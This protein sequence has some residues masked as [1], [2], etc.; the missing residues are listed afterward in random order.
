VKTLA[1]LLK[2]IRAPLADF[3]A[4]KNVTQSSA[5]TCAAW[6]PLEPGELSFRVWGSSDSDA[7]SDRKPDVS[8]RATAATLFKRLFTLMKSL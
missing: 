8:Q 2:L 5:L 3:D 6:A 1:I 4:R 7:I